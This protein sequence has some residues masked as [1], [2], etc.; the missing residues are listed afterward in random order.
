[1][2]S[3]KI[4]HIIFYFSAETRVFL[5]HSIFTNLVYNIWRTLSIHA[6]WM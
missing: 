5:M 2:N 4:L 1:M 3:K 6:L